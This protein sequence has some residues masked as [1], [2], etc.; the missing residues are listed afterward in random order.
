MDV[1]GMSETSGGHT[2]SIPSA[3]GL[4]GIGTTIPGMITKVIFEKEGDTTGELCLYGRHICM[5]YLNE[6]EKT[7][8]T[9]DEEGWLHSGD[10]GHIDKNGFVYITGRI[11][12]LLIT[13]GGENVPPVPIETTLKIELPTISNVILIGDQKKFLSILIT[14][15]TEM[16]SDMKPLDALTSET[17]AWLQELGCP[18]ENLSEVFAS[19]PDEKLLKAIQDGI[20]KTNLQATSNAQRIQKFAILPT[21][22]SIVT[23]ELGKNI[24]DG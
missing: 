24:R 23:G 11:K 5:G 16:D 14:L 7:K 19:G 20:D 2:L 4:D 15:K 22:F 3:F 17:K 10:I 18:A 12:E 13:A 6:P 9:I 8:E 21:D 1:F